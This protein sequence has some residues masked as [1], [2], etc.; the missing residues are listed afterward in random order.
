MVFIFGM[1]AA[2]EISGQDVQPRVYTP[3]P[4]GVNLTT[5]GYSYST[6]SVLFDKTVPIDDAVGE[7]H[8]LV[9]GYSR[10]VGVGELAGRIDVA[11]PFV[12]G[13]WEG[14]VEREAR[15]T[16]R[17]GF[18]DPGIRLVLGIIGA[19]ALTP[20]EFSRFRP[21]TILGATA[22]IGVPLGQYD[23]DRLINLGSNRWTFSPQVGLSQFLGKLLLEAYA[24]AWFFTRNDDFLDGL[25]LSQEP[26]FTFQVHVGYRFRR[27]LWIAASSRQSFGGATSIDGGE[28]M[29]RESNNRIGITLAI[30]V[31]SRYSLKIAGTTAATSTAGNDYDTI[32]AAWQAVF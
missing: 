1:C 26:L 29:A 5:L 27:G 11:L 6:G 12:V 21:R 13:D 20:G 8:S 15:T 24:G 9:A 4:V 23:S 25:T 22:R 32:V 17:A 30:P 10:S 3:A 7:I 19:P 18:A 14:S 2:A 28:A 16:S 31:G